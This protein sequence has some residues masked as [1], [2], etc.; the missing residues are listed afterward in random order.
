MKRLGISERRTG[1]DREEWRVESGEC[2]QSNL[3]S[4]W[5]LDFVWTVNKRPRFQPQ[6]R[7]EQSYRT[8]QGP[9]YPYP[10]L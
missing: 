7:M 6:I 3:V 9:A 1:L 2:L 5:G 8:L 10:Y 4:R